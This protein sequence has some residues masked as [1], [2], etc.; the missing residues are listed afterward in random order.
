[1]NQVFVA[2]GAGHCPNET[3]IGSWKS[4]EIGCRHPVRPNVVL[5]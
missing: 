4:F 2:C 1:M 5:V 3:G